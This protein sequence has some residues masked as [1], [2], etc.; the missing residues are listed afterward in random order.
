MIANIEN[1]FKF[2]FRDKN[3]IVKILI[4]GAIAVIPVLNF[5]A[6]GYALR[7]LKDAKGG[8][9]AALPEWS[10][11]NN[12]FREGLD[13]FIIGLLYGL[14]MCVTWFLVTV[15]SVVPIIG[16]LSVFLFPIILLA[17][18]LLA[19]A[20]NISLCRYLDKGSFR[21]AFKLKE[22][23]EE[24]KSKPGDYLVVTLIN[25]GVTLIASMAFCIAPFIYFWLWVITARMFGEIYGTRPT[26][27]SP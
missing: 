19:P 17:L 10:E 3:W 5:I 11:W 1:A 27:I 24:F 8:R 9:E 7:I 4:G 23:Y 25:A 15:L 12:L 16:C 13:V 14:V 6:F 26:K 18:V 22:V 20:L 2:V 21:E